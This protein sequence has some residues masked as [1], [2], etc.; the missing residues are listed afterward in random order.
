MIFFSSLEIATHMKDDVNT[1]SDSAVDMQV[2]SL[3][4]N[5]LEMVSNLVL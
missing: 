4:L 3:I 1:E 2:V 5:V